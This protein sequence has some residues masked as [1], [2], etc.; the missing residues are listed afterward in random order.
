MTRHWPAAAALLVLAAVPASA[1]AQREGP[2]TEAGV[3]IG[4][5][6]YGFS[7]TATGTGTGFSLNAGIAIPLV[8]RVVFLEPSLG[9]LSYTTQFGNHSSWMFPELSLQVQ[10]PRGGV[11]PYLGAGIGTGTTGLSGPA[12][13]KFTMLGLAGVRVHIGG[14][15]GVRAEVR[16][17][18][19]DPWNGH[20]ADF[21]FGFTH[22]S[23]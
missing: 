19:V 23:F 13:W 11:R 12:R 21:G 7:G 14:R 9:F 15:W 18:S 22:S 8:R 5:S 6:R 20:T 1:Q 16:L 17:R 10:R 2:S 3:M 4:A